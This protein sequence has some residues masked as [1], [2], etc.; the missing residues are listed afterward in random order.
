MKKRILN[1]VESIDKTGVAYIYLIGSYVRNR[2]TKYSDIDIKV[3]YKD[4]SP[5]RFINRYVDGIYVSIKYDSLLEQ[6]EYTTNPSKYIQAHPSLDDAIF[7]WGDEKAFQAFRDEFFLIE[8]NQH[9]HKEIVEYV[10]K[11][12]VDWIEEVNKTLNGLILNNPSKLIDGLYG[13]TFGML[14]VLAVSEGLFYN[15]KGILETMRPAF[16][17]EL[18]VHVIDAFGVYDSDL[19]LR[20]LAGL[21]LYL[22][23]IEMISYRF[24]DDTFHNTNIIVDN[25]KK[26]LAN[27]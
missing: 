5:G 3:A 24:G 27:H 21:K 20:A 18:F 2:E 17:E 1:A 19:G 26:F 8:Y 22:N 23:I 4:D 14:H 9:F 12:T 16:P 25:V 15:K 6:Q 13:L 11:E 7:L 10:N